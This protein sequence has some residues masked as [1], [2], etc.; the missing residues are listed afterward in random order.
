MKS[1]WIKDMLQTLGVELNLGFNKETLQ[2]KKVENKLMKAKK[3]KRSLESSYTNLKSFSKVNGTI[4]GLFIFYN[5]IRWSWIGILIAIGYQVI[6]D[7]FIKDRLKN[8]KRQL[9]LADTEILKLEKSLENM[10]ISGDTDP[11]YQSERSKKPYVDA[12]IIRE[13]TDEDVA[14]EEEATPEMPSQGS[15]QE[16]QQAF[17]MLDQLG[18]IIMDL[19]SHDPAI[20]ALFDN[21]YQ[22]ARKVADFMGQTMANQ[23]KLYLYYN[24]VETLFDWASNLLELEE[25]DVYDSLLVNVKSNAQKALPILQAKIDKEYFKLVNPKIMDLEAE[26]EVMSKEHI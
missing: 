16:A 12:E 10:Y 7:V 6:S 21:T 14:D 1:N 11:T 19:K 23:T 18:D 26:M 20:G 2:R 25:N 8:M 13:Y 5:M 17:D 4:A 15:I 24:Y 22:S 9:E 3:E